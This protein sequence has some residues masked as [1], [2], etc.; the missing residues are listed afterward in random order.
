MIAHDRFPATTV[1]G[2]ARFNIVLVHGMMEHGGRYHDFARHL[3]QHG[4][5][6]DLLRAIAR[7]IVERDR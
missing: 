6:A 7:F 4:P 2:T 5:E 3:A 1:D